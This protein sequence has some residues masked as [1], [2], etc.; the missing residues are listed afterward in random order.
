[1]KKKYKV[2][3]F[4]KNLGVSIGFLKHHERHGLLKPQLSSSG[5]RYY[6]FGQAMQVVQCLSLQSIGFT[7]KEISD[8]M[9]H[10]AE[11]NLS[12]LIQEKKENIRKNIAFYEEMLHYL[13]QNSSSTGQIDLLRVGNETWSIYTPEPFYFMENAL[14]GEFLSK[15][16]YF[17]IARDWNKYV[18]MTTVCRKYVPV[19]STPDPMAVAQ[20]TMGLK[21]SKATADRLGALINEHVQLITPGKCLVYQYVGHRPRLHGREFVANM[22]SKPLSIC[23]AH[24]FPVCGDIFNF[25][26]FGS[27]ASDVNYAREIVLVPIEPMAAVHAPMK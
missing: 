4:A 23:Q 16:E 11:L 25:A 26:V 13:E 21:L 22:L 9:N 7:S 27:T 20:W 19:G 24:H 14:E 17:E 1:M 2:G 10:S 8:I 18:P 12:A 5:Y 3:E 15:D 6:E